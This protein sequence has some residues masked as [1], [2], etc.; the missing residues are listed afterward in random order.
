MRKVSLIVLILSFA[1]VAFADEGL[2]T[3]N[4]FPKD[5]VRKKYAWAPSDTWLEHV[6]LSSVRFN[7]GGSGSFVS[8]NGLVM[9]N[10]HVGE[11]CIQELGTAQRDYN[12]TGFYA[13]EH[14]KEAA[15]PQLEL[16]VLMSIQDVTAEVNAAVTAQMDAAQRNAAQRAVTA[17]IEKE[18]RDKTGLRCD[19]VVLY[20]GG[21]FNLYRY[22]K[23]TDVR[24][25]FAP[26]ASI[27]F[28][29]GDPDNFTYPRFDFD[30]AFF[31]VYEN[32]QPAH[33]QHFLRWDP[34]G[35]EEGQLIFMS[36]RVLR[37]LL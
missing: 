8:P 20:E 3:Y 22:K 26:E 25:V 18:C 36:G 27:A 4:N 6:R 17:G 15:C 21:A 2:W 1:A 28:F 32:G 14:A 37:L 11:K 23:Y 34:A 31:R 30:V 12:L 9:T 24:L 13:P 19:V 35:P 29:G 7:N 16:N 10:H 5:Q 33:V